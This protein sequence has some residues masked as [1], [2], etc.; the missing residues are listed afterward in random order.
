[1]TGRNIFGEGLE[2]K[3]GVPGTS[4]SNFTDVGTNVFNYK[5]GNL[6]TCETLRNT[7]NGNFQGIAISEC[8]AGTLKMIFNNGN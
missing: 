8:D 4:A 5:T 3:M 1:M 2:F 7:F 6:K